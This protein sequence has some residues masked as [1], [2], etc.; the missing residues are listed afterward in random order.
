MIQ[1]S[2]SANEVEYKKPA[3]DVFLSSFAGLEKLYGI[4]DQKWVI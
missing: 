1:A 3:P 2:T 4:P